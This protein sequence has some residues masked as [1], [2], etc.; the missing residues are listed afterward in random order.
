MEG[1]SQSSAFVFCKPFPAPRQPPCAAH[2]VSL[3]KMVS[4]DVFPGEAQLGPK[5]RAIWAFLILHRRHQLNLGAW[6]RSPQRKLP[7][8][9]PMAAVLRGR[10]RARQ[11]EASSGWGVPSWLCGW[12]CSVQPG[13]TLL[14]V[15]TLGRLPRSVSGAPLSLPRRWGRREPQWLSAQCEAAATWTGQWHSGPRTGLH[16]TGGVTGPGGC[17]SSSV[18][19]R[20]PWL[21]ASLYKVSGE[22]SAVEKATSARLPK[23]P[24]ADSTHLLFGSPERML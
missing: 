24:N 17:Q 21:A 3:A 2:L 11:A 4:P 20:Q 22:A 9:V 8:E 12:G 19:G 10:G 6:R 18:W 1:L 13:L 16:L 23:A 14:G 15:H 7:P 5:P